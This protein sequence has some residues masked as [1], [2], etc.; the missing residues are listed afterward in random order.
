MSHHT[1]YTLAGICTLGGYVGYTKTRSRPSLIAG[2][3]FGALYAVAGYLLQNNLEYGAE[4]A[5]GTS[6]LLVGAMGPR[7]LK[8]RKPVP[9]GLATLGL[10]GGAYYG[11]KVYE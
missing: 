1:A 10:L 7:A 9:A 11:R 5:T 6:V 8:T 2:V 3:A 4:L